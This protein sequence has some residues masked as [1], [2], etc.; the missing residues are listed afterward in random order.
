MTRWRVR[1]SGPA[2]AEPDGLEAPLGPGLSLVIGAGPDSDARVQDADGLVAAAHCRLLTFEGTDG[3]TLAVENLDPEMGTVLNGVY[4]NAPAPLSPG[5]HTLEL[6]AV[7]LSLAVETDQADQVEPV[8]AQPQPVPEPEPEPVPEPDHAR[9]DAPSAPRAPTLSAEWLDLLRAASAPLPAPAPETAPAVDAPGNDGP[10]QPPAPAIGLPH[11]QPD[12]PF[13]AD[14]PGGLGVGPPADLGV[15]PA[16]LDRVIGQVVEQLGPGA[17]SADFSA[18]VPTDLLTDPGPALRAVAELIQR[19]R[20]LGFT[21][22]D[23]SIAF[24]SCAALSGVDLLG[25]HAQSDVEARALIDLLSDKAEPPDKRLRRATKL[26]RAMAKPDGSPRGLPLAPHHPPHQQAPRAPAPARPPAPPAPLQSPQAPADAEPSPLPVFDDPALHDCVAIPPQPAHPSAPDAPS[27]PPGPATGGGWAADSSRA[28]LGLIPGVLLGPA[29]ETQRLDSSD[30]RGAQI[31]RALHEAWTASAPIAQTPTQPAKVPANRSGPMPEGAAVLVTLISTSDPD[32][33]RHLAAEAAAM[34]KFRHL[35]L[36]PVLAGGA[37]SG[38]DQA[39]AAYLVTPT[40]VLRTGQAL[41]QAGGE[42]DPAR[43]A[44]R[45]LNAGLRP[46][47]LDPYARAHLADPGPMSPVAMAGWWAAMAAEGVHGLHSSGVHH[48]RLGPDWLR[49]CPSGLLHLSAEG[50]LDPTCP[51]ETRRAAPPRMPP[52]WLG[53]I[54]LAITRPASQADQPDHP[55]QLS[56]GQADPAAFNAPRP[57]ALP[58]MNLAARR[59]ADLWSLGALLFELLTGRPPYESVGDQAWRDLASLDP[60]SPALYRP[61]VTP[62]IDAICR[63]A[64]SR[65]PARRPRSAGVMARML[66][67]ALEPIAASERRRQRP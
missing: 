28:H 2:L 25:P 23:Q 12:M 4:I 5:R 63:S 37:C 20:G 7:R 67:A 49:V 57:M 66:R 21:A 51:P 54:A 52:E 19:G 59:E 8:S 27:Y 55:H 61:E 62:E 18:D 40:P 22:P 35:G 17:F 39:P 38:P 13:E 46:E 33:L 16:L 43:W 60:S 47:S 44:S 14:Q 34:A 64:L 42:A 11:D 10:P 58:T 24:V 41:A 65:D 15:E 29:I 31:V 48:G 53:V 45:L 50:I 56:Q 26:A 1:I 6:A 30:R 9:G 3:P 32:R 36:E